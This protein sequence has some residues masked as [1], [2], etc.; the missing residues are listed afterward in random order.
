MSGRF[1][2]FVSYLFHP[3]L[4]PTYLLLILFNSDTYMAY[5]LS[6]SLQLIIL[7]TVLVLTCIMPILSSFLLLRKQ[8]VKNLMMEEK[9]E[10]NLPFFFTLLYYI[11]CFYFLQKLPVPSF[12]KVLILAAT[13]SIGVALLI[14]FFWKISVH[15]I[16][17]GGLT[18][19]LYS[20]SVILYGNFQ[21]EILL[22]FIL[23]GVVGSA[24]LQKES[25]SPAQLY[26]GFIAGFMCEFIFISYF[27]K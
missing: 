26:T 6:D 3:L 19:A 5:V 24:R 15:M 11:A 8:G 16:G 1:S 12:I 13:F 9:Q 21:M 27:M 7:V 14:N 22:A 20:L 4:I 23:S 2:L 18:G 25:H 17:M 10:R